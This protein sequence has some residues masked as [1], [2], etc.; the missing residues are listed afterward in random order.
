MSLPVILSPKAERQ[1]ES[2]AQWWAENRSPEQAERWYAGLVR[3]LKSLSQRPNR[4]PLA[5]ENVD[6]QFEIRELCYGLGKRPT[7]RA[8]FTIQ[9]ERVYVLLIRHLAQR[10]ISVDDL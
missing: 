3:T 5:A 9:P 6:F 7:H 1:L 10:A 2:I 4:C 8:L